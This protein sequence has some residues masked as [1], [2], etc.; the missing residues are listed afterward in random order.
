[1]AYED[2]EVVVM[3]LDMD[4]LDPVYTQTAFNNAGVLRDGRTLR[5]LMGDELYAEAERAAEAID[6]PV[7]VQDHPAS[8]GVV[9]SVD[10]IA[11]IETAL[12]REAKKEMLPLQ[13]GDVPATYADI[14]DLVR[15]AGF[16]PDTPIE[17]GI[18]RFIAWYRDY[19]KV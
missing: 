16:Q 4:D 10:F 19:Y 3:E 14:D 11:A 5:D 12:G 15:D 7:V 9:M 8:S 18:G 13:Q 6:I 17:E 1:M 2:A